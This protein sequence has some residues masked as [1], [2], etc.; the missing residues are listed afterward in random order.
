MLTCYLNVIV[1][2]SISD[3]RKDA[4]LSRAIIA[5]KQIGFKMYHNI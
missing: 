3:S 5:E 1:I 4:S 2:I